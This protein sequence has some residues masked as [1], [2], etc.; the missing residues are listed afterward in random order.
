MP[1]RPGQDTP[2]RAIILPFPVVRLG[3]SSWLQGEKFPVSMLPATGTLGT[4]QRMDRLK[5]PERG[6]Q[7]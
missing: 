2:T 7:G 5:T 4:P 6:D 1:S 3:P